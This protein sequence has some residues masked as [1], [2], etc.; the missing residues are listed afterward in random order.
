MG[1]PATKTVRI[2]SSL[3]ATTQVENGEPITVCGIVSAGT[4]G[5]SI[6][7]LSTADGVTEL[8]S[9]GHVNNTTNFVSSTKWY[10]DKGLLVDL[11]TTSAATITI[12]YRKSG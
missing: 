1:I 2:V 11:A 8:V 10:A 3:V 6:Q 9:W 7:T 12:H 5:E 4:G